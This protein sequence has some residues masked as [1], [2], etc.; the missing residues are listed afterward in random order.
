MNVDATGLGTTVV[1]LPPQPV[2]H[3]FGLFA[4]G[5]FLWGGPCSPSPSGFSSSPGLEI[6]IQAP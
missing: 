1:P 2:Y 6:R 3:G 5:A 4:Q